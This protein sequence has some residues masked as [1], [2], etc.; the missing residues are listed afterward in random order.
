[1]QYKEEKGR[2]MDGEEQE[3]DARGLKNTGARAALM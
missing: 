1:M 2:A 3:K